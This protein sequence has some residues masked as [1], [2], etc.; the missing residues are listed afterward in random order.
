MV[1]ISL[2]GVSDEGVFKRRGFQMYSYFCCKL[3][4]EKSLQYSTF[5]TENKHYVFNSHGN[6]ILL[7][8][9]EEVEVF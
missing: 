7:R 2:E 6:D 3:I 9:I 5:D 1:D 4:S 8:F